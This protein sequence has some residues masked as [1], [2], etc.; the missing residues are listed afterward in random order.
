[1]GATDSPGGDSP[2]RRIVRRG[3]GLQARFFSRV[4]IPMPYKRATGAAK[5]AAIAR[6]ATWA[7]NNRQALRAGTAPA[8]P[9][10]IYDATRG[11]MKLA[12][13]AKARVQGRKRNAT[14]TLHQKALPNIP[15]HGAGGTFSA[16]NMRR[17]MSSWNKQLKKNLA[18]NFTYAN[19]SQ[20]ITSGI[21]SQNYY[22]VA[23]TYSATDIATQFTSNNKTCK[24]ILESCT[25]NT[26]YRN[27]QKNDCYMTIYDIVARRDVSPSNDYL[28]NNAWYAGLPDTGAATAMAL[29]P[30]ATPFQCPRFTQLFKIV[31]ATH[32]ILPAGGTHEHRVHYEPNRLI[33]QEVIQE[34]QNIRNLTHYTMVVIYGSPE[35][36]AITQ[37]QVS[38]GP[39]AIDVVQ[40]KQ[41]KWT[42]VADVITNNAYTNSLP[43]AFTN[44]G[45]ILQDESGTI[46]GDASA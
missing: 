4:K 11:T 6:A 39:T 8:Y 15:G 23:T 36:D 34:S 35:N 31:K 22:V 2:S 46:V 5:A 19:S 29:A 40:T 12:M 1:M 41:Y 18:S 28:P 43:V 44:F 24:T 45:E 7:Y 16:Y 17:R 30:G 27:Q 14:K 33:N 13:K 26:I 10:K 42:Y 25:E 32:V 3:P 38:I 20:R 9:Q 21:G 37:T